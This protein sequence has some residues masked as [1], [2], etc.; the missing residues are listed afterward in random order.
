MAQ[1]S[2]NAIAPTTTRPS[3]SHAVAR[4]NDDVAISAW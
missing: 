4:K 2:A 3:H 1:P